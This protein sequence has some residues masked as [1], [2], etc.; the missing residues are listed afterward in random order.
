LG[1][2]ACEYPGCPPRQ[3]RLFHGRYANP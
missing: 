2:A 3:N 1:R